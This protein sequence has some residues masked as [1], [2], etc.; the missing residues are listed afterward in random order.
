MINTSPFCNLV[1]L[2]SRDLDQAHLFYSALGLSFV[3]HAHGKGPEHLASEV[4]G[5]VFE[6]Y[7][8][9]NEGGITSATRVGFAVSSVD[10]A[11]KAVVGAGGSS[12]S[13]PADAP[14]GRRAVVVDPD[15]H[16]VELTAK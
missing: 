2:R 9:Q 11:Y 10:D 4:D 1:V 16:R 13:E 7:P 6:I 3:R 5:H 8:L 12:I 14:W 15:G